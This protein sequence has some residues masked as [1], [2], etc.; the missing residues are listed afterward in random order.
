MASR[1]L[2]PLLVVVFL[3]VV[4]EVVP[5]LDV[6]EVSLLVE[7]DDVVPEINK[8]VDFTKKSQKALV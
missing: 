8:K 3:V 2:L 1:S 6:A 4:L 5:V 7:E